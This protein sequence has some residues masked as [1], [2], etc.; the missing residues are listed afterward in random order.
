MVQ[1]RFQESGS[2]DIGRA[3]YFESLS[4]GDILTVN[5]INGVAPSYTGGVVDF[6]ITSVTIVE[7]G[8]NLYAAY[9]DIV[10]I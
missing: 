4:S 9:I 8:L 7:P 5:V 1:L 2:D 3:E 6:E 10:P